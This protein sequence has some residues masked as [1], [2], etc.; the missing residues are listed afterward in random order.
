MRR[1]SPASLTLLITVGSCVLDNMCV[2]VSV[3]VSVCVCA[4]TP[5]RL[6]QQ[7]C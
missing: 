4:R 7:A 5:V 1:I 2:F 6:H 3:C